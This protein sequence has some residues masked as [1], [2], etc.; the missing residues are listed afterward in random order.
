MPIL[1]HHSLSAPCRFVRLALGE[2]G[3]DAD[4]A[5]ERPWA[6]DPALLRVSPAGRLPVLMEDGGHPFCGA[7]VI[8][9]YLDE[10]RG[11]F[12]RQR[13]LLPEDPF[14]RGEVR[15]L[16]DWFLVEMEADVTRHLVR[17]RVL[18]LEMPAEKGGGSPNSAALRAARANIG[19][20]MKYLSW[21]AG[22]RD[23]L[24]GETLG[25]ADLAAA[26]A[27]SVLDYLGEVKWEAHPHAGDWYRRM[28]SRRSFRP[29]LADRVRAV[30]PASHYTD[31][32]F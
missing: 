29:L 16:V 8:G 6:P 18:K 4:L 3:V 13:R 25:Y 11:P 28:K 30:T 9:E 31:L 19:E 27:L 10:T 20:H 17:E 32:D 22:T 5:E 7:V 15:R 23:W 1:Y 24:A 21:L 26:A 2:Y 14:E 12:Q